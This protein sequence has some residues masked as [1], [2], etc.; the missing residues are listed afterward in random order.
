MSPLWEEIDKEVKEKKKVKIT[1]RQ[2]SEVYIWLSSLSLRDIHELHLLGFF[3]DVP[4]SLLFS[5]LRP[6]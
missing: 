5:S 6:G 4:G 1:Y 3:S 2:K